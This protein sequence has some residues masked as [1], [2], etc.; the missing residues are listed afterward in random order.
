M[1][2]R[3]DDRSGATFGF[4]NVTNHQRRIDCLQTTNRGTIQSPRNSSQPLAL[5]GINRLMKPIGMPMNKIAGT[6]GRLRGGRRVPKAKKPL[7]GKIENCPIKPSSV[8]MAE[9]PMPN[10]SAG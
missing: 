7:A 10:G 1:S 6:A 2:L 8:S 3:D 9:Y 5:S 4:N